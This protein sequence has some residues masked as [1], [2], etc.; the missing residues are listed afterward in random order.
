MGVNTPI[1]D[2]ISATDQNAQ[3]DAACR[4]LLS[5]KI[6]L[7]WIMKSCLD[8][9]RDCDV[10]EIAEKYIESEPQVS[11]VAVAPDET[12]ARIRG[13][14]NE[15][16]SLTEGKITYDVRF[17][18]TVPSSGELIQIIID[19][20]G[21]NKFDPGYP[22]LKRAVYYCSRMISAQHGTEFV[23]SEYQKIK[24]VVSIWVCMSPPDERKNTITRYH[25]TE[26]NLVG[27][28]KEPVRNYDLIDIV[29]LCLGGADGENYD[30]VLKLLDVLLSGEKSVNEKKQ[31]LQEDFNIPMTQTLEAE[32]L[33]MC[34]FSKGVMQKGIEKGKAEGLLVAIRN[35]MDSMGWS[36]EQAMEALRIAEPDRS[37]YAELLQRQ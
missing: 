2:D 23:H 17:L 3:Y 19:V 12:N 5:E 20:E 34:N 21:Q 36:V 1:A 33:A 9:Y 28:V 18:A 8:E 15:D 24:K 10:K 4:R 22:L 13:M 26:E 37:K 11:K 35:L 30:G 31:V 16:T 32:V 29:I 25:L 27:N 14:S 7:A 6:V